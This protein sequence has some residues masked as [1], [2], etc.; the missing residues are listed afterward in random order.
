MTAFPHVDLISQ[1]ADC[2]GFWRRIHDE[3]ASAPAG[4]F[5]VLP[6]AIVSR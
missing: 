5:S 6:P 2:Q 1:R 4:A 3:K